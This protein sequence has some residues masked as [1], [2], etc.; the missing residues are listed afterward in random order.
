MKW[1]LLS[2]ARLWY[3]KSFKNKVLVAVL[4][5]FVAIYGLTLQ[6]VYW[7]ATQSL[8]SATKR[9]ALS[10]TGILA[11]GLYRS[12]EIENEQRE[13]QSFIVGSQR[14]RENVLEINILNRQLLVL[15]STQE[16]NISHLENKPDLSHALNNV[17][18]VS[19]HQISVPA[20][21]RVVYPISAGPGD[22]HF[23]TGVIES[24]FDISE[25]L[26]SLANIRL[27]TILAGAM[28]FMVMG[29]ALSRISHTLTR[30]I[31]SLY[32]GMQDVDNN[33]LDVQV[34][35][36]TQD[37]IGFL[38]TTF[39]KMIQSINLMIKASTRFVPS[40]FLEMLD[41]N[42][43]TDV[44]LGDAK[45]T[46][47]TVLFMDIRD[48]T[49][50]SN[51]LSASEV[52]Q[53]LNRINLHLLPAIEQNHGFIDKYIGDAIMA[54]FPNRPDDALLA[55]SAMLKGLAQFNRK[56][57]DEQ[58]HISIGI[59][60]NSGEVIVGT[61]GSQQRMDTTVIGNT[62]NI[63]SRLE[64]LTKDFQMSIIFSEE[65]YQQLQPTTLTHLNITP[66][67]Q[68]NVKGLDQAILVYGLRV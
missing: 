34:P 49:R 45:A 7:Q 66:L 27:A 20:Y 23:V 15:A 46:N 24:R 56:L 29:I 47:I 64:G 3:Q 40:E 60:I 42:S 8:L 41:K 19:I 61:V 53:F 1:Q 38:S 48:F 39:N 58:A 59:G 9:E 10:T 36:T 11:M 67:G 30:P 50:F 65:V 28:I 54:I 12:Y 44:A 35:V 14:Y 26:N 16:E 51:Y 31:Q 6:F 43:F 2:T 55:A 18:A 63:A 22:N 68:V 21:I 57:D 25:Q 62:V 13:I 32:K 4:S 17:Y 5:I 33:N 37:E 52:L